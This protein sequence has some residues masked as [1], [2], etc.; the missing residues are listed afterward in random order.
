MIFPATADWDD[1]YTNMAYI[2]GGESYFA[3]WTEAARSFREQMG[4]RHCRLDLSYGSAPRNRFD[5]FV[6]QST[7]KGVFVFVH[8]GY[9]MRFDKNS[10]SHLAKGALSHGYLAVLPSYTLC[11]D[12][13]VRGIVQ[14]VAS[15][16][17]E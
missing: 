11:P 10:F 4:S 7:M 17:I 6:P 12:I 1:A 9:W 15:A 14:E 2:V 8:G 16:I 5:V 13:R 3:R